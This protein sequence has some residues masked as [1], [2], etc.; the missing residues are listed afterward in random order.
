MP[1]LIQTNNALVRINP[2]NNHIEE[3]TT[4][5]HIWNP[6]FTGNTYGRFIDLV[7]HKGEILASTERGVYAS[8]TNGRMWTMR[9]TGTTYGTF[10]TLLD[11]GNEAIAQTDRGLYASRDGGRTW[12]M[13]R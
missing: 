6:V 12:V 2:Q 7:F 13:R 3:S 1:Q 5:G 11:A 10:R 9:F 4:N 8:T